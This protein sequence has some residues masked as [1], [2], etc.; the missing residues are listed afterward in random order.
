METNEVVAT[1][2]ALGQHTRLAAFTALVEAG[3]GGMTAGDIARKLEA[4]PNTMSAH[5]TILG[6]AG[7]VTKTRSGKFI[8]YRA[9]PERATALT[10]FLGSVTARE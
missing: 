3:E 9:V 5:L 2:S 7:L 6:A 4:E 10:R 8:T 1:M